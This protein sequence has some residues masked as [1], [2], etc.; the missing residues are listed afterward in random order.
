MKYDPFSRRMFLQGLGATLAIPFLPSLVRAQ[1]AN[2]PI[3][4]YLA[5][6]QGHPRTKFWPLNKSVPYTQTETHTKIRKLQD[7]INADGKISTLFDASWNQYADKM[8]FMTHLNMFGT[9]WDHNPYIGGAASANWKYEMYTLDHLIKES[10]LRKGYNG[11]IPLLAVNI[12]KEQLSAVYHELSSGQTVNGK[13]GRAYPTIE[14]VQKLALALNGA[15]GGSGG[16]GSNGNG[17]EKKLVD[18]VLA[19]YQK[20]R[21]DRRLSSIDKG[22]L[23]DAMDQ[24]ND[25][26]NQLQ[27]GGTTTQC[28]AFSGSSTS[29][30]GEQ[31][32][33]ATNM[34]IAAIN[35]GITRVVS[36]QIVHVADSYVG[37]EAIHNMAHGGGSWYQGFMWRFEFLKAYADKLTSIKDGNGDP[38]LDKT[39]LFNSCEYTDYGNHELLGR[40]VF[41]LGSGGGR[42]KTGYHVHGGGAPYQRAHITVMKAMGLSQA[43]IEVEGNPGFGEYKLYTQD[44]TEDG[45][46]RFGGASQAD[47]IFRVSDSQKFQSDVEKRKH[48]IGLL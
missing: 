6:N 26:Q 42:I 14:N 33:L 22:R 32:R 5:F 2:D 41:T 1:T 20:L 23:D 11:K 25:I 19:D 10:W 29:N 8:N 39:L 46:W 21:N 37:A 36:H 35:C 48:L 17:N 12:G 43:E 24:W 44:Y 15:S 13:V 3:F 31:N 40:G 7:I 27:G 18:A 38:L 47:G 9:S 34:I 30:L 28:G 45:L 16:G 4:I